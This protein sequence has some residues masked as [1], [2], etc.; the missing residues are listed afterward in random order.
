MTADLV[1]LGPSRYQTKPSQTTGNTFGSVALDDQGRKV[2]E[3]GFVRVGRRQINAKGIFDPLGALGWRE[4]GAHVESLKV[5]F[6]QG[7][8]PEPEHPLPSQY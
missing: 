2:A 8:S 6:V 7:S 5:Q 1:V 3:K 4:I